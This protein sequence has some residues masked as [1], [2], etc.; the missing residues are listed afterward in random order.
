MPEWHSFLMVK[1]W[2][3]T[4]LFKA[5]QHYRIYLFIIHHTSVLQFHIHSSISSRT[6]GSRGS[7]SSEQEEYPWPCLTASQR[8]TSWATQHPNRAT[9]H[10]PELCCFLLS[11]AAPCCSCTA[12]FLAMLH[13]LSYAALMLHLYDLHCTLQ[14]YATELSCALFS[15]AALLHPSGRLG[16]THCPELCRTILSL[17]APWP[18]MLHPPELRCPILS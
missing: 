18:A 13:F 4:N 6:P 15:Y 3:G 10:P 12:P 14:S 11:Y 17:D 7:L 2:C 8:T 16:Y 1:C 5:F 9:L